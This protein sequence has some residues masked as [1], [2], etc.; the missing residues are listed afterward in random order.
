[1]KD[2]SRQTLP[3]DATLRDVLQRLNEGVSGIVMIVSESGSI[4][5][6]FTDGDARRAV[7]SAS[8]LDLPAAEFMNRSF[9][10]VADSVA[11]EERLSRLNEKIRHLPVVDSC[12]RPVE[13]LSWAEIWKLPLVEPSLGGNELAYVSECIRTNWISSQGAFVTRFEEVFAKYHGVDEAVS[14]SSGTTALHLA[15]V[16]MGIGKGDEVIV[17]NLT[18]G[19]TANAVVHAGAT[20][21]FADIDPLDWT[22]SPSDTEAKITSATKA[23]IPVHLYGLP[24]RMDSIQSLAKEH[25]LLVLEDCAESLGARFKD[26][27]TGTFGEA[28]AFSFFANKTI[29]TGEGGMILTE[30]HELA[31]RMRLLRDHGMNKGRRYWHEEPGYN[32]RITNMQSA[33]GCAQMERLDAFLSH[34]QDIGELYRDRL[35]AIEGISLQ[36]FGNERKSSYW[37]YSV[38]LNE[39][40]AMERD[41]LMQELQKEGIESRP[42][43]YPLDEQPAYKEF[44]NP[45]LGGTCPISHGISARGVSLPTSNHMTLEEAERVCRAMEKIFERGSLPRH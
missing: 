4:E 3:G 19:A 14:V 41:E 32:Y 44:V 27:L 33:V 24:A 17:P 20:P 34:R 39:F 8:N 30:D 38:T 7:L 5:G 16:A 21:V 23:I 6:I 11:R 35:G 28:S 37:L 29:T 45:E 13:V 43:F 9:S 31:E 12:G 15:L 26:Q 22:L 18:F 42:M 10:V 36:E 25:G 40:R 1:M 2:L